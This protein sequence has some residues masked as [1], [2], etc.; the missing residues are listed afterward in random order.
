MLSQIA[1][2]YLPS[3]DIEAVASVVPNR[4]GKTLAPLK[5]VSAIS[6]APDASHPLLQG[7]CSWLYTKEF[8][9]LT[10]KRYRWAVEQVHQWER[11]GEW[12]HLTALG[13]KDPGFPA[14]GGPNEREWS[15]YYAA[16]L[17]ALQARDD[18][19]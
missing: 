18:P 3:E 19:G 11:A 17:R 12:E 14:P 9:R 13:L 16:M 6:A 2:R 8:N 5:R 15:S 10:G 4:L 1:L 7:F